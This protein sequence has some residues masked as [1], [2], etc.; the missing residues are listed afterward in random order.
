VKAVG[1]VEHEE[2]SADEITQQHGELRSAPGMRQNEEQRIQRMLQNRVTTKFSDTTS[3][4]RRWAMLRGEIERIEAVAGPPSEEPSVSFANVFLFVAGK[5]HFA[6][7]NHRCEASQCRVE[8][9]DDVLRTSPSSCCYLASRGPCWLV[10]GADL[11][12]FQPS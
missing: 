9:L 3:L 7:G 1:L 5:T 8:R 2:E 4:E 6:C 11:S 10:G 12:T